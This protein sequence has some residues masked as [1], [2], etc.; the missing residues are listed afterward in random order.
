MRVNRRGGPRDRC[1]WRAE[2]V[3]TYVETP[4]SARLS[5]GD[6]HRVEQN[7]RLGG[8]IRRNRAEYRRDVDEMCTLFPILGER[9]AQA[10]GTLS[11]GEQQQLALARA[12]M[13]HPKLLMLD[14]PSLGLAPALVDQVFKLVTRL[15]RQGMTILLVEQN[16]HQTLDIVD[17]AYVLSIGRV[18]AAGTPADL[19]QRV[20]LQ[21][22]YLGD[23]PAGAPGQLP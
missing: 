5:E 15:H 11:G 10:A 22:V 16:V 14:E 7:L 20:N 17:R 3:A 4:A 21:S 2:W 13:S 18:E 12:L 19:R 6:R 8:F 1:R 23:G 9:L